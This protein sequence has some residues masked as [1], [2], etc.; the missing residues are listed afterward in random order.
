MGIDDGLVAAEKRFQDSKQRYETQ[1]E[2]FAV[3]CEK[4]SRAEDRK[5]EFW[6]W[7]NAAVDFFNS[8]ENLI[9]VGARTKADQEPTWFTDKAET[10]VNLL[11]TIATHYET[12]AMKAAECGADNGPPKP[13]RTAFAGIQRLAQKTHPKLAREGRDHFIRLGL[14]THGFDTD[15][16]EKMTD[17]PM[18]PRFFYLGCALLLIAVV[19]AFW[20]FSLGELKQDQRRIL[21]WGLPLASG[22]GSWTFAGGISAKAKSWQG[23]VISATGGFAVWLLTFF[24]LFWQ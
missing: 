11:E 4:R 6:S 20:G 14:P 16:S 9:A 22:F 7:H 17:K 18:E 10:A 23:F 21:V 5:T 24:F 2:S 12:A 3:L 1:S 8:F 19:L 13:S 15:E